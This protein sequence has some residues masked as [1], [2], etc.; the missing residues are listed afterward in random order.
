[1]TNRPNDKD[2]KVNISRMSELEK[3]QFVND[4]LL[5]AME[6]AM[7]KD[8]S[9]SRRQSLDAFVIKWENASLPDGF[10]KKSADILSHFLNRYLKCGGKEEVSR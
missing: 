1:M 7:L 3:L 8:R 2:Q 9:C 10:E 4:K 5:P 6:E